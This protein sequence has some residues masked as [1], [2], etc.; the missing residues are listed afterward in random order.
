MYKE[1]SAKTGN[2]VD[3]LFKGILQ[4]L[5][6]NQAEKKKENGTVTP[7]GAPQNTKEEAIPVQP[8]ASKNISLD[9]NKGNPPQRNQGGC[10]FRG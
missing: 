9:K 5:V 1:V 4:T 2:G 8:K 6:T 7:N 10:C 3:E